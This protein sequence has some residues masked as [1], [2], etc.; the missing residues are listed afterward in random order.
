M[1]GENIISFL[2]L[3]ELLPVPPLAE[4][5]KR[6]T[7]GALTA[8][9]DRYLAFL[10]SQSEAFHAR[11]NSADP[12]VAVFLDPLDCGRK[13]TFLQHAFLA[14]VLVLIDPISVLHCP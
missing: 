7:E 5:T 4:L 9:L 12:P 1:G 13:E 14:D 8:F 11:L 10:R 3:H 2:E 6:W